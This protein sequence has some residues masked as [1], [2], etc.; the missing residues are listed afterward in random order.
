[1]G[2]DDFFL[3]LRLFPDATH[4]YGRRTLLRLFV[5]AFAENGVRLWNADLQAGPV[6]EFDPERVVGLH[7]ENVYGPTGSADTAVL[8]VRGAD[9]IVLPFLVI[10]DRGTGLKPMDGRALDELFTEISR[11]GAA[12]RRGHMDGS[13][14]A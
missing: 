9:E 8:V 7:R 13:P 3:G 1:M 14:A 10:S 4:P 2:T 5:I 12:T 11:A 6:I